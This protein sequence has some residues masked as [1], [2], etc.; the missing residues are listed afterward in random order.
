[1]PVRGDSLRLTSEERYTADKSAQKK[2]FRKV[3]LDG[4]FISTDVKAVN[5]RSAAVADTATFSDLPRG[6]RLHAS[7]DLVCLVRFGA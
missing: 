1:M 5:T 4:L 6:R 7:S 3:N 2:R